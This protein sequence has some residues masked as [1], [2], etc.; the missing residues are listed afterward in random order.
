[1]NT[2]SAFRYGYRITKN[3]T[4]GIECSWMFPINIAS[5]QNSEINNYFIYKIGLVTR[6]SILSERRF[7]IF[8]EVSPYFAHYYK[9]WTSSFDHSAYRVNKLGYYA[10]PGVTLYSKSKKF[11]FDLYYKFSNLSFLDGNKSVFSYK[12]NYNF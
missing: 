1:M 12:V 3:I 10:A 9:E 4:T 6:Y 2:V 11:S 8:A 5:V 7:R